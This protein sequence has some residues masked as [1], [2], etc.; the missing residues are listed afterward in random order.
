M[1]ALFEAPHIRDLMKK[2][3]LAVVEEE[4][5]AV[6]GLLGTKA[7]VGMFG[8]VDDE[9]TTVQELGIGIG[10]RHDR[11]QWRRWNGVKM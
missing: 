6:F 11:C 9:D 2:R 3:C 7:F 1:K 10:V 5:A 8:R 4:V